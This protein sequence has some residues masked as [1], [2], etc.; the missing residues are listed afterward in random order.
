MQIFI[1]NFGP[2]KEYMFDLRKDLHLIFG[3]N[4]IGKSYAITVVYLIVKSI[5]RYNDPFFI[6][7]L[8]QN[9]D[10]LG[11]FPENEE[12]VG[13]VTKAT[14]DNINTI[15][16]GF[17]IQ[18][19]NDSFVATF[20]SIEHLQNQFT[21]D[22]LS[23]VL[24]TN[25]ID[26]F[27]SLKDEEL[28]V[29]KVLIKK[30]IYM[31]AVKTNRHCKITEDII[32]YHKENDKQSFVER[33]KELSVMLFSE[34]L[35]EGTSYIDSVYLLPASR[36]GL[37]QALNAFGQIV[38]ELAKS[39]SFLKKKIEL[40]GIS[41][42]LSDYF[43]NLSEINLGKKASASNEL[44]NIATKIERE[45]LNGSVEIDP[46]TKRM[47][48]S[49]NNTSLRLDLSSTSSMVSEI[50]PIVSFI[51]YILTQPR[52]SR[53]RSHG[54]KPLVIIEEPEAH[55]HPSIQVK[56][57][58]VFSELVRNNV[59]IIITSH[60]NYIFN[61]ANNLILSRDVSIDTLQAT[62]FQS[63]NSGSIGMDIETNELGMD[64]DN[65]LDISEE[66]MDERFELI[67]RA[68]DNA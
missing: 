51:R 19:L 27:I 34:F 44:N 14:S 58:E 4:N 54:T 40:P 6:K 7:F 12:T 22:E 38:A 60:S 37:Y 13:A 28:V 31:R 21:E 16:S 68:V 26:V 9:N 42:P 30:N 11:E 10:F 48:F 47:M 17:I 52:K 56:L 65:F 39:R 63:N 53:L 57:M 67:D 50:S 18:N 2:I 36:S 61:K 59:K 20:D 25:I 24:S 64:D 43:L 5:L 32:F 15:I 23:I 45:V 1:N 35:D 29:S 41:E 33:V 8:L 46:K 62:L 55:I 49:P 3:K 66:L